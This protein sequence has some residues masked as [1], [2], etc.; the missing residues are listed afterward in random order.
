MII[1]V[2]I[3]FQKAFLEHIQ[4]ESEAGRVIDDANAKLVFVPLVFISLRIWGT[5]RFI[6]NACDP[7]R[8]VAGVTAWLAPLQVI[9]LQKK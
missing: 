8:S 4:G 3:S 5:L 9:L 2:L 7:S 6:I 1:C